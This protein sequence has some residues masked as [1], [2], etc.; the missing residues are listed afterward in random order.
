M[1]RYG[2]VIAEIIWRLW[3]KGKET[4]SSDGLAMTSQTR[5][6]LIQHRHTHDDEIIC[7][8]IYIYTH[9]TFPCALGSTQPLKMSTR[10]ELAQIRGRWRGLVSTVMKFRVP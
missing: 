6:T 5:N 1:L 3:Y 4:W 7:V 10:M 9:I 8:C 2:S